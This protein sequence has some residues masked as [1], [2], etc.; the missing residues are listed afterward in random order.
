MKFLILKTHRIESSQRNFFF[1]FLLHILNTFYFWVFSMWA[2]LTHSLT[3]SLLLW[4]SPAMTQLHHLMQ[5]Y[6]ESIVGQDPTH[7]NT[8]SLYLNPSLSPQRFPVETPVYPLMQWYL[9][10]TAGRIVQCCTTPACLEGCWW[11]TL[12]ATVR[13]MA[14]GVERHRTAQ[15]MAHWFMKQHVCWSSASYRLLSAFYYLM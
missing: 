5:S 11:A 9:E 3:V 12:L 7:I 4:L 10:R 15:V 13:K 2:L 1:V 8:L 14:R 6:L